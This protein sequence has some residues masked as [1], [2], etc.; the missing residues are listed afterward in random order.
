M[1][2]EEIHLETRRRAR[3][4][5][6]QRLEAQA[7]QQPL[8]Y[9]L[10]GYGQ[11]ASEVLNGM[12]RVVDDRRLF[13]APE[14][15]SRF[16]LDEH[17]RVGASWMTREDRLLEMEDQ[18]DYL[19]RVHRHVIDERE[20]LPQ[21]TTVLGFS[22][23]VATATRWLARGEIEARRLVLWGASIPPEFLESGAPS[24]LRSVSI[25]TVVGSRDHL[26]PE[27]ARENQS[28]WLEREGLDY[29]ELSFEGGHRF[30]DDTL[31]RLFP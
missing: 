12:S 14:G 28:Q 2:F 31:T 26:F 1:D 30:D 3:I 22:Q 7:P 18:I 29:E 8:C 25:A 17:R 27:E 15:L 10:H 9:V 11:L 19:N 20:V 4:I 6:S 21:T 16:Y 5:S 13:I 23:G 24:A